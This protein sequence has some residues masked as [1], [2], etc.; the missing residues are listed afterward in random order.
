MATGLSFK[1]LVKGFLGGGALGAAVVVMW[2]SSERGTNYGS[3]EPQ[4]HRYILLF[5]ENKELAGQVA[6]LGDVLASLSDC[7]QQ[8]QQ[9]HRLR[10]LEDKL[11][12]HLDRFLLGYATLKYNAV[13]QEHAT[14]NSLAFVR[15]KCSS[16][17]TT[18]IE[19]LK[20]LGSEIGDAIDRNSLLDDCRE[21]LRKLA[22]QL[23]SCDES[24]LSMTAQEM[25]LV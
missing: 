17:V 25:K 21:D 22:D 5:L 4:K 12:V 8:V 10:C 23:R 3:L 7:C 16:E 19:V 2:K 13:L 14:T 20:D 18:V 15:F 9:N 24:I 1:D 11:L 6:S